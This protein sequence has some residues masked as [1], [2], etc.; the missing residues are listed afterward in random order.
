MK[1]YR[2]YD[3][4][5]LDTCVFMDPISMYIILCVYAFKKSN[6]LH[7]MNFYTSRYV[8]YVKWN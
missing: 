7:N 5:S 2:L 4:F 8:S 6:E 1:V 3:S